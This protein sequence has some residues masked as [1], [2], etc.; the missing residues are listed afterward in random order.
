[1]GKSCSSSFELC[2]NLRLCLTSPQCYVGKNR[3]EKGIVA[4][5]AAHPESQ[6]TFS[7]TW[8]PFYLNPD[9]PKH[10]IDKQQYY[11]E[12]FGEQRSKMM[13]T[14]LATLGK[15]DGID[16]NF[17][18]K[19]GNTR[20]SHR[21]VQLGKTKSPAMQTQ[22]VEALFNAYF[23]REEDI[24]SHDVLL[25]AGVKAGLPEAEIHEWL[26][27]DKGGR[28]VDQEVL[29][30]QVRSISGVPHFTIQGR[31]ELGGAQEPEAFVQIF[32]KIRAAEA[33]V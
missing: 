28:E 23:E 11:Y 1:M 7:T 18:G 4:Y 12:K 22:V 15:A 21:L 24:T 27:S 16:F 26:R 8:L 10:G 5:E 19:T 30:A 17:G 14:R 6:D 20:D 32:E 31:Y 2:T 25:R 9:A 3:L 33:T 29:E 13:F